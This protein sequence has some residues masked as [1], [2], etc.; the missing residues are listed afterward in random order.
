MSNHLST[1][2][3]HTLLRSQI[4]TSKKTVASSL[5][6]RASTSG[7]TS[8]ASTSGNTSRA[9]ATEIVSVVEALETTDNK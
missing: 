1:G 8:R 2:K 3:R 6:S 5:V 4:A 7:N 9:S